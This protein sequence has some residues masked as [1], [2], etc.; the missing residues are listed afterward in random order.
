[1]TKIYKIYKKLQF[2]YFLRVSRARH[3]VFE[4]L[5]AAASLAACGYGQC[6][7]GELAAEEVLAFADPALAGSD[8]RV[9]Y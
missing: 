9:V 5:A 8:K 1:M 4:V 6:A 7:P 2:F 3:C